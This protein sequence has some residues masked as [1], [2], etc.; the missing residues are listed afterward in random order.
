MD[1]TI[2]IYTRGSKNR[3]QYWYVGKMTRRTTGTVS[4]ERGIA[5]IWNLIEEHACRLRPVELGREYGT[6]EIW[7]SR[8]GDTETILSQATPGNSN[9][10]SNRSGVDRDDSDGDVS[11]S[12]VK[13]NRFVYESEK[14]NMMEVG[15]MAEVVTNRGKGFYIIR[16]DEGKLMK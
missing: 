2:D 10:M 15:F 3:F 12:L 16:D 1:S 8:K 9:T 6:L 13:M 11:M 4:V 5:R 7:C 14:V